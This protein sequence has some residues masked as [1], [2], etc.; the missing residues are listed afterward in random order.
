MRSKHSQQQRNQHQIKSTRK[1]NQSR[2]G[3]DFSGQTTKKPNQKE[4]H[5]ERTKAS[6]FDLD[7]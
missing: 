2:K 1:R 7:R 6:Q 5:E 4:T 3:G